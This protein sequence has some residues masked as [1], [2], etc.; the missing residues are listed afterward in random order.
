M[1]PTKFAQ[2]KFKLQTIL[3]AGVAAPGIIIRVVI[4]G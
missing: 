1:L 4:V 3:Y 2:L